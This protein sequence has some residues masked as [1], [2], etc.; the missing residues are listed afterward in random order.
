MDIMPS[1]LVFL[2]DT[3]QGLNATGVPLLALRD[4]KFVPAA[5]TDDFGASYVIPE[6]ARLLKLSIPQAVNVFYYG[7]IIVCFVIGALGVLF[8][9]R[10]V[11]ERVIA[12]LVMGVIV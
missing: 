1:R 11:I 8:L 2:N 12:L 9:F 3:L 5:E 6:M 7:V 10:R 4:G